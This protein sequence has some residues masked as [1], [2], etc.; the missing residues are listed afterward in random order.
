MSN[1]AGR[2]EEVR[3]KVKSGEAKRLNLTLHTPCFSWYN[4]PIKGNIKRS[5]GEP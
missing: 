1:Y 2:A 3:E 5:E 4:V